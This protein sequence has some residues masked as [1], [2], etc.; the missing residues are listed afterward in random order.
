MA[1]ANQKV[2]P[3]DLRQQLALAVK[4]IQWSYAIFWSFS[5]Q[6]SGALG[7]SEGYYNGDIKTRK[8]V[9]AVELNSDPLGLQRSDQLRE[10]FE[11]LSLGES[12]PQPKRPTAALSPEDLTDTEWY[13][14]VCMSFVFNVGQGLPGRSYAENETIW[15][16]NA[17]LADTKLFARSLLA[18][19]ASLQTVVCFPH[20]GG[21]VELGTTELVPEDRGLIPHIKSSFLES[22]SDTFIN[23]SHDL[24]Y[25]VLDHSN[26]PENNLDEVEVYSPDTSSDEFADNVLIEGS[27]LADGADGE[28]DAVSNGTNNATSSSDCVSQTH[29]K[30]DVKVQEFDEKKASAAN[31]VHVG[32]ECNQQTLPSFNGGGDVHYHNV[33]SSLLKSSHQLILGP[34]R[35]G[36]RGSSFISWKDRKSS[37]R[38]VQSASPQW[39]LK[40]VLFEVA[41]MHENAQIES[42]KNKDRCDDRSLQQEGEEVDKNHVLSERKRR[43]KISVRFAI[44]GSLVPSG[45]KVDK[46]S[47]LDHTIEYLREL[48]RK[49]QDLEAYKE[50]TERETTQSRAHDAMERTSDNYGHSKLGSITK[51][52]GNKKK[53]SDVEKTAPENKRTRSTSSTDSITISITDKDV[54]IEM[55]C[56]WRQCV[57]IQV[58][59]ALTQL[60][61]ESQSV[62]SSNTDGILSLS[63]NAKS[64]GVKGVSAGAIKQALQKIIKKN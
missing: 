9:Q 16:R 56:S 30:L 17:H 46:V 42:A 48:E 5:A 25:Q 31:C 38:L 33:L 51:L 34:Y 60:N 36:K 62:Q 45:G 27:C 2:V 29:G 64:K 47:V 61:L 1:T 15:L 21:V 3:D 32:Q 19:S 52:L 8:T 35:N 13:F 10:L 18:K 22:S 37:P 23:L 7:W 24:V 20:L 39:L 54:L 40:K 28:D 43:E 12:T 14:L 11:S 53:A 26:I 58:M 44:L 4:S 50:A 57:L 55:R 49:V 6:Q 59:E 41:R 63:I